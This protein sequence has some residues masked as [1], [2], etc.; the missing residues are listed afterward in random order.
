ME[1]S[2]QQFQAAGFLEEVQHEY[3]FSSFPSLKV[4]THCLLQNHWTCLSSVLCLTGKGGVVQDRIISDM[5]SSMENERPRATL[6]LPEW[7][8]GVVLET[9]SKPPYETLQQP[10]LKY[11]TYK[12]VFLLVMAPAGR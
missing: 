11:L 5:I 10:S 7:D 12:M 2:M 1:A 6:I 8:L 9:L 3:P 4:E